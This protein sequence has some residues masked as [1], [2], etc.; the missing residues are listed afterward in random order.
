MWRIS[1]LGICSIFLAL[2]ASFVVKD[3]EFEG[4]HVSNIKG[5]QVLVPIKVDQD[6]SF[7]FYSLSRFYERDTHK[8]KRNKRNAPN[9]SEK[10]HYGLTFNG[11]SHHLE[12]WPNN[13]FMSP[14]VVIEEWG[15]DAGL[16][17]NKVTTR[18]VNNTQCH[19]T[20]RVRGQDGSRL[21]LSV[22]DVLSGHIKTNQGQNFIEPMTGQKPQADGKHV[23]V[24]YKKSEASA[25]GTGD[26]EEGWR[27]D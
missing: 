21:A 8:L 22:C 4:T 17:I 2:A 12:L 24:V 10:V 3:T 27:E 18:A 16:D 5:Y 6:G 13:G 14:G 15:P 11:K 25:Y 19:Y 9:G 23:H 1:P 26:G 20:G 7:L